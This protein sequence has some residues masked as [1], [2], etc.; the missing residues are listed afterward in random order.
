LLGAV[1]DAQIWRVGGDLQRYD[2]TP[3]KLLKLRHGVLEV[4]IPFRVLH[5]A[6]GDRLHVAMH[7]LRDR[8][9]LDRYPSGRTLSLVVPDESFEDANW[10]V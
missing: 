6:A 9:E 5:V 3:L 8:V 10:S 2:A 1:P 4:G 7:L